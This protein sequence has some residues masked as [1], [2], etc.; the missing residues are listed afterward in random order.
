MNADDTV[1][2]SPRP[3]TVGEIRTMDDINAILNRLT[4]NEAFSV[5]VN[6][7]VQGSQHVQMSKEAFLRAAAEAWDAHAQHPAGVA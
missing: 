2:I 7:A 4:F 5:L 6:C 3:P 1:E